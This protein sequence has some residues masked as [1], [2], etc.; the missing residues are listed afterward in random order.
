MRNDVA[1][2][3][4]PVTFSFFYVTV[5]LDRIPFFQGRVYANNAEGRSFDFNSISTLGYLMR[6]LIFHVR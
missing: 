5:F 1:N 3:L 2:E 6:K 4:S